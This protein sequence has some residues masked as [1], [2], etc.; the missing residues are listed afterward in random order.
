MEPPCVFYVLWSLWSHVL[1]SPGDGVKGHRHRSQ[2]LCP[3][4][5]LKPFKQCFTKSWSL[6]VSNK[7]AARVKQGALATLEKKQ[8]NFQAL[9]QVRL[10]ESQLS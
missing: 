10:S 3:H 2:Q 5:F 4:P 7:R 1:D 6:H 9:N 8:L